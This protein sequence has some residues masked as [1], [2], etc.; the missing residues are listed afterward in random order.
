M[1]ILNKIRRISWNFTIY[2]QKVVLNIFSWDK[3]E[4]DEI[5]RGQ[6][7]RAGERKKG[8]EQWRI[9]QRGPV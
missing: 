9:A 4:K 1:F 7:K 8:N 6:M 3:T 2:S 5:R